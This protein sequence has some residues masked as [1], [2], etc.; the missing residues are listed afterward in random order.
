LICTQL[1][2]A[3]YLTKPLSRR[4][5]FQNKTKEDANTRV[6]SHINKPLIT[7]NITPKQGEQLKLSGKISTLSMPNNIEK[8]W[9]QLATSLSLAYKMTQIRG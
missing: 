1:R 5:L 6:M 2:H 7:S 9:K 8:H 3:N 4:P